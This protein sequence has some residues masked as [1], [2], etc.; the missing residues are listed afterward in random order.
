MEFNYLVSIAVAFIVTVSLLLVLRPV[1]FRLNLLDKPDER[2]HHEGAVP[3]IGG[4]SIFIA[5]S[6]SVLTLDESL[7][8]LKPFFAGAI[9]LVVVGVLDDL[10]E[11]SSRSRFIVQIIAALIMIYWGDVILLDMGMLLSS[12]FTVSLGILA[13]PI[14]VFSAIGVVNALNMID[15]VDGLA[16]SI[17]LITV[18]ALAYLAFA[19]G[20]MSSVH[21][22]GLVAASIVAFLLFNWR[23]SGDKKAL[24]FMGDAGSLFLGF[25]LAWFLIKLSQGEARAMSPVTALWIF[26]FPLI[27]T[28]TM[29]YRRIRKGKSPFDADREHFHHLLQMIG[30]SRSMV[31]VFISFVSIICAG[32]GLLAVHYQI[33]ESLQFYLFLLMFLGYLWMIA[34]AWKVKRFLSRTFS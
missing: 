12:S 1:A 10:H 23:H 19:I 30:F 31:V 4:L 26:A 5:L 17:L 25:L 28:I 9:L 14:T 15:G 11:L 34:R 7:F 32:F 3:L 22:L 18:S 21:F 16:G 8:S 33:S 27:D 2:K 20:D 29:M 6:L 13:V 24:V